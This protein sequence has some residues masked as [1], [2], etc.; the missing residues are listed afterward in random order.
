MRPRARRSPLEE[1]ATGLAID[2]VTAEVFRALEAAGLD[3]IL[4]KGQSIARRLYGSDEHRPYVDC[5]LLIP[6]ASEPDVATVLRELGFEPAPGFGVPDPGVAEQHEWH[7]GDDHVDLHGSLVGIG[8]ASDQVWPI[9]AADPLVVEVWGRPINALNDNAF[10]AVLALH[11][12]NDGPAGEK[13]LEDLRRGLEMLDEETWER[14]SAVARQ[15]D[16]LAAFTA[17][18]GLLESGR[19][20]IRRLELAPPTDTMVILRASDAAPLAFSF[21]RIRREP[22]WR[23]RLLRIL[24]GLVPAPTYMRRWSPLASRSAVGLVLAYL[25]RPVWLV[26]QLAPGLQA[27]WSAERHT[28][29]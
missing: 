17:G 2:R 15:L 9:L 21:E 1:A 19:R 29:D 6:A 12:A 8:V 13:A 25:W 14:A 16:A 7:R 23:A 27:W 5:D 24:R 20:L 4:L 10:A 28:H 11:A 18:L 3:A 22:T 26:L